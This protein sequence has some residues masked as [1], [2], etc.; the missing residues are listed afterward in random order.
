MAIAFANGVVSATGTYNG[1]RTWSGWG[2][3]RGIIVSIYDAPA[4]GKSFV[5]SSLG[6]GRRHGLAR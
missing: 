6:R 5:F 3:V 1:E 2:A 4:G